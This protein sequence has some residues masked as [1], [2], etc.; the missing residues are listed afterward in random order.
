[1]IKFGQSIPHIYTT[2][3]LFLLIESHLR[4]PQALLHCPLPSWCA[5]LLVCS[6]GTDLVLFGLIWFLAWG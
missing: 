4:F 5:F 1:V 6:A 3:P 2:E